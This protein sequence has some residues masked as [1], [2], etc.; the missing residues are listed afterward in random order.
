MVE[1]RVGKILQQV[2]WLKEW[3]LQLQLS[4]Q[5]WNQIKRGL[6]SISWF[7]PFLPIISYYSASHLR[8]LH[9]QPFSKICL[10]SFRINQTPNGLGVG[11][12]A[13]LDP[14]QSTGLAGPHSPSGIHLDCTPTIS[15]SSQKKTEWSWAW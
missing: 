11:I 9:I 3:F 15:L 4:S 10:L 7:L 13:T 5:V 12:I 8:T 1:E 14:S 6:A 2:K